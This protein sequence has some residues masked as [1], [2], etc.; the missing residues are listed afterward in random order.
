MFHRVLHAPGPKD[1]AVLAAGL[2]PVEQGLVV[3]IAMKPQSAT[4]AAKDVL[5]PRWEAGAADPSGHFAHRAATE[6]SEDAVECLPRLRS[7][8]DPL[9]SSGH[10]I[11]GGSVCSW[12]VQVATEGLTGV[13]VGRAADQR[14]PRSIYFCPR[15]P[16]RLQRRHPCQPPA[17][18]I[19]D[20]GDRTTPGPPR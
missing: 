5:W 17:W 2:A 14:P 18:D 20:N 15:P 7:S 4:D 13:A 6:G 9:G 8:Q 11:R 10:E 3:S 12:E 16:R 19:D 1:V